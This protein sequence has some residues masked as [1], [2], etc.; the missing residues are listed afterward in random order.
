MQFLKGENAT[1]AAIIVCDIARAS[2][3]LCVHK[4]ASVPLSEPPVFLTS[5]SA[6]IRVLTRPV[7]T[8]PKNGAF[9]YKPDLVTKMP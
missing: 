1:T 8:P 6:F 9:G 2:I 4:C 3:V 5:S 7:G